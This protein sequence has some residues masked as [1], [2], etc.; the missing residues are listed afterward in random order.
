MNDDSYNS[1]YDSAYRQYSQQSHA[2]LE[3]RDLQIERKY[4]TIQLRE[5]DRGKFL[6]ITE[7]AQGRRNTI[8]V[9]SSG[10]KEFSSLLNN[11]LATEAA[12]VD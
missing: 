6:R 7:E 2:P 8:I 10:F 4:F 9:P 12:Q 3:A 5:N 11:I 1:S